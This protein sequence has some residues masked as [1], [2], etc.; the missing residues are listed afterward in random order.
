M[1]A[2]L[3]RN[4]RVH[5]LALPGYGDD[6]DLD[7]KRLEDLQDSHWVG[8]SMGGLVALQALAAGLRPQSLTLIASLPCMVARPDW[9]HA[10][11]RAAFADFRRQVAEDPREAM[12]HF[13]GLVSHGDTLAARVRK[14]LQDAPVPPRAT[15]EE[16]LDLLESADLRTLWA[17]TPVPLHGI[18]A[19]RDALIS[20]QVI[21]DL[22]ALRPAARIKTLLGYGHCLPLSGLD[23]C[24]DHLR[25][26]WGSLE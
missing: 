4:Y 26:F 17:E 23:P 12:R 22:R 1:A 15:L 13:A 10:I 20:A 16:G 24:V 5:R 6:N 9:P 25:T 2:L 14:L 3:P 11:D 21:E 8:W 19:E 7:G 18:L